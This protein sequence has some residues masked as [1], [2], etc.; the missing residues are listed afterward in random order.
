M[1]KCMEGKNNIEGKRDEKRGVM[2]VENGKKG[3]S[4]R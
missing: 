2:N 1:G 3:C 4:R